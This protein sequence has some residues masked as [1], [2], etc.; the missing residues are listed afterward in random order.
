MKLQTVLQKNFYP[1]NIYALHGFLGNSSHWD[2]FR[3]PLKAIDIFDIPENSMNAWARAFNQRITTTNNILL[4][5]SMGGRLSLH[6][7][8]NNPK[9]WK[10]A[11]LVSTHPG[12]QMEKRER[13]EK[14]AIWLKRFSE[15]DFESVIQDWNQQPIFSTSTFVPKHYSKEKLVKSLH[16]WSLGNQEDLREAISRL[17]VPILWI[18]GARDQKYVDLSKTITLS[19][20]QSKIWIAANAA[21]R[22]PWEVKK[23]FETEVNI[24]L[25]G[26]L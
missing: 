17:K 21:H 14:D 10:A 20:P 15:E 12:L 19:H 6:A 11:I 1:F 4:G 25:K 5:Y 9:Q 16:H 23:E 3:L 13:L 26:V 24:F 22:V 18:V 7:L 2:S 8:I